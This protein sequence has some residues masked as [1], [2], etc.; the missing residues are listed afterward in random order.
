VL[1]DV[2]LDQIYLA[3]RLREASRH[4]A[5]A[6]CT[7]GWLV[8]LLLACMLGMVGLFSATLLHDEKYPDSSE[9]NANHNHTCSDDHRSRV[10]VVICGGGGGRCRA[11]CC[12][13]SRHRLWARGSCVSCCWELVITRTTL[14]VGTCTRLLRLIFHGLYGV[15]SY[16]QLPC[17]VCKILGLSPS[18]RDV[19]TCDSDDV[20]H[21]NTSCL[22]ADNTYVRRR[23]NECCRAHFRRN[24]LLEIIFESGTGRPALYACNVYINNHPSW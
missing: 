18:R 11:C 16:H 17:V 24:R 19:G 10:V 3:S 12:S 4:G 15:T 6:R 13:R 2:W 22:D 23:Y 20:V 7:S 5:R 8:H 21:A 9:S 14:D 1:R